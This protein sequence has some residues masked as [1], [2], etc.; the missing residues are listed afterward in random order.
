[1]TGG[2]ASGVRPGH[3]ARL[4]QRF[5]AGGPRAFLDHEVLEMLLAQV[6]QRRDTKPRAYA[7]IDAF[8]PDGAAEGERP[9]LGGKLAGV[10]LQPPE[11]LGG[12]RVPGVGPAM[13]LHLAAVR[14]AAARLAEASLMSAPVLGNWEAVVAYGNLRFAGE[15]EHRTHVL[16]LD[17]RHRLMREPAAY[18][19]DTPA[20]DFAREV[21]TAALRRAASGLIVIR[22]DPDRPAAARPLD[23]EQ[24]DRL[25]TAGAANAVSL[26]DFMLVSP[27]GHLSLRSMGLLEVAADYVAEPGV[28]P[29]AAA[30]DAAGWYA[31]PGESLDRLQRRAAAEGLDRLDETSLL[32]LLLRRA[33]G[34]AARMEF[35][36][37]LLAAFGSLGRVLAAP[38]EE[39][40][41][42]VHD[43][44]EDGRPEA[45]EV[46]AVHLGVIGEAAAR[47]LRGQVLDGPLLD[48]LPSLVR[49]CR[50][51]L[52][53]DEVEQFRLLFLD[54]KHRLIWD[55]IA[56]RGTVNHAPVQP[57]EV[58]ARALR[59][60]AAALVL[61]HNHPTGEADP[62]RAD[63]DMTRQIVEA[64]GV[65]GVQV[66]DHLIVAEAGHTSLAEGGMLPGLGA[67]NNGRARAGPQR[68][69][70][71]RAANARV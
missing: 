30:D 44:P 53:Y 23:F 45:P 64:C 14:A 52:G 19:P 29:E 1:M 63:I 7:L 28:R 17:F 4:R 2:A 21:V 11:R 40:A 55:E 36:G 32:A 58:T 54:K 20:G 25:K 13:A 42:A 8:A 59:L 33:A 50:A 37:R 27:M 9:R 18:S 16:F 60:K 39:L 51:A 61:V 22:H 6:D 47:L 41:D 56:A 5:L 68:R 26:H 57:R 67:K 12:G 70:R 66:L 62:S 10:L 3:R 31:E 43:L 46:L 34:D 71:K 69:Q 24:A 35:A 15:T 65:A 38:L 48:D 49:Y